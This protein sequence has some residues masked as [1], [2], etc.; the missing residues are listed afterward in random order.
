MPHSRLPTLGSSSILRGSNIQRHFDPEEAPG[1]K[2]IILIQ[3]PMPFGP[4]CPQKDNPDPKSI[5]IQKSPKTSGRSKKTFS[6]GSKK[7]NTPGP[8][9][10]WIQKHKNSLDPKS[11][12]VHKHIYEVWTNKHLNPCDDD[13]TRRRGSGFSCLVPG[14]QI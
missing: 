4:F 5:W 10:I 6:G 1:S 11:F 13:L 2:S 9:T 14:V 8:K 7:F 12:W 3:N